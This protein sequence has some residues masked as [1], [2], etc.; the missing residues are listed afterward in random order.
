M[1]A[2]GTKFNVDGIDSASVHVDELYAWED[3]DTVLSKS[4]F[5]VL[6]CPETDETRV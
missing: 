6:I 3:L 2:V 1:N 5:L 4:D